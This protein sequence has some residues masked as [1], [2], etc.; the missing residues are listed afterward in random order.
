MNVIATAKIIAVSTSPFEPLRAISPH[1]KSPAEE[2]PAASL[3]A[4]RLLRLVRP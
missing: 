3:F 4:R 2:P 1:V